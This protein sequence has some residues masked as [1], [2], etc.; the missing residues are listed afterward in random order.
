M[1]PSSP[2]ILSVCL[3]YANICVYLSKKKSGVSKG[4][5]CMCSN[6]LSVNWG[7]QMLCSS[8]RNS[9]LRPLGLVPC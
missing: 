9:N 1:R 3:P 4:Y 7:M 2:R 8:G 6:R 5:N